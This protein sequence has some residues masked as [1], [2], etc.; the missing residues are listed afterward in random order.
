MAELA[1]EVSEEMKENRGR[2]GPQRFNK[3]CCH[4]DQ[5]DKEKTW[6]IR[7]QKLG[8]A[9]WSQKVRRPPRYHPMGSKAKA[10]RLDLERRRKCSHLDRCGTITF[11]VAS[12]RGVGAEW[13]WRWK[14]N[15][16]S[17]SPFSLRPA[18][19]TGGAH[20]ANSWPR[21]PGNDA[22]HVSRGQSRAEQGSQ[23]P[24]EL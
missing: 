24:A 15:Q 16:S 12:T 14:V 2:G 1:G 9:G 21:S 17:P 22:R 8:L 18:L 10:V 6:N 20:E 4:K 23:W 7:A 5:G 19:P 13:G 11:T 3:R